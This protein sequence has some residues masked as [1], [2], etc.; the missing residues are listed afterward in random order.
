MT[1]ADESK[2]TRPTA[3]ARAVDAVA[4]PKGSDREVLL[5]LMQ[6][7][8]AESWECPR[9]GH[10]ETTADMDSADYLRRYLAEHPVDT[11]RAQLEAAE[12][13]IAHRTSHLIVHN[14]QALACSE[15]IQKAHDDMRDRAEAAEAECQ[16]LSDGLTTIGSYKLRDFTGPHG[17]AINCVHVA[18]ETLA[19]RTK[20]AAP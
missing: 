6:Q 1:N 18:R 8:D 17:M 11:L 16:R 14:G 15:L 10:S 7:F 3:E 4:Y 12:A 2:V 9:C 20:E 13:E 5:Y 19:A